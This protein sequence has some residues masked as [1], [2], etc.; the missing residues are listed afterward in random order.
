MRKFVELSF[1]GIMKEKRDREK[2]FHKTALIKRQEVRRIFQTR[3][4]Q[5]KVSNNPVALTK[6]LRAH[7]NIVEIK[8][9]SKL[10]LNNEFI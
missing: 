8:I 4:Y 3:C 2:S 9:I 5:S 6:P 1:V 7:Q 10:R